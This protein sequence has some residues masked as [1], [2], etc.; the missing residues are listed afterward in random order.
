LAGLAIA[1][2][3]RST[4]IAGMTRLNGWQRIFIL[5]SIAWLV[6]C[7]SFACIHWPDANDYRTTVRYDA[8]ERYHLKSW[9][10]ETDPGCKSPD[11]VRC[12]ASTEI[13]DPK[14]QVQVD[15]AVAEADMNLGD[16]LFWMRAKAAGI[17]FG[18][19]L[20]GSVAFYIAAWV[21]YATTQWVVQGFRRPA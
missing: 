12:M 15:A 9:K 2:I 19:W 4:T 18:F 13:D 14:A 8:E 21:L 11:I 6:V 1:C 17:T 3:N 20:G 7:V 16:G 10:F 5:L